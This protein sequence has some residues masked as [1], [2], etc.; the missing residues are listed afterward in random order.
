MILIAPSDSDNSDSDPPTF[1]DSVR[2]SENESDSE[3]SDHGVVNWVSVKCL[4][5]RKMF[6][7]SPIGDATVGPD[8]GFLH[9]CVLNM[10]W[11]CTFLWW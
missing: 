11:Y 8:C 1:S 10:Y 3:E 2:E 9:V 7:R 6:L 4:M 5:A